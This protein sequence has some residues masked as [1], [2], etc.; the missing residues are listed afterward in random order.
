MCVFENFDILKQTNLI[1]TRKD[2]EGR[3]GG[4]DSE[5]SS[6]PCGHESTSCEG[7]RERLYRHPHTHTHT[8]TFGILISDLL[9][10]SS[11]I[12]INID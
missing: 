12:F 1:C 8:N 11:C 4:R 7:E 6:D 5:D 10:L 3:G 9:S 2:S